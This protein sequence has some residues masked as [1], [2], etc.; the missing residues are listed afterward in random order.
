MQHQD[1]GKISFVFNLS[2]CFCA[3]IPSR[4]SHSIHSSCLFRLLLAVAGSQTLLVLDDLGH[5]EENWSGVL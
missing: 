2:F 1:A 5:P 3:R 4:I